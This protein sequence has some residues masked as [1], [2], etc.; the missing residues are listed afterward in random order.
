MPEIDDSMN[1]YARSRSGPF[2]LLIAIRKGS[3]EEQVS[4]D[5]ALAMLLF[6]PEPAG[7]LL[8]NRTMY[9]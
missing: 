4:L 2:P 1:L 9:I 6:H 7:E 3:L 5:M 8:P